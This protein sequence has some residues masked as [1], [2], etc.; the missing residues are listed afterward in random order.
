MGS[1][2]VASDGS[3]ILFSDQET[4][5]GVIDG[6]SLKLLGR[7]KQKDVY[8]QNGAARYDVRDLLAVSPDGKT[9]AW[10]GIESTADVFL[11]ELRTQTVRRRLPGDSYPVKRLAYSPDGSKLLSA[12]PDGSA[13]V[14]DLFDRHSLK[15][16][17]APGG[18]AV[19]AWWESLASDEAAPA[20]IAMRAMAARPVEALKLL[21]A[22]LPGP[23]VEPAVIDALI[24]R[25]G[26]RDFA[27]REAATKE[28]LLIGA[29]EPKLAAAAEKSES[30]EVRERAELVL[31]RLRR[32]G[33]LQAERAVEV[34]EWI[35]T[36][37][38][39]KFLEELASGAPDPRIK[40]DA[41]NA[42]AR[43]KAAAR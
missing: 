29:A 1:I 35:G 21:R 11:I 3:R 27:T 42:V 39:R 18:K 36:S 15:P 8:F 43:R 2:A 6:P 9:V 23:V 40:K 32:T 38:T 5:V 37:E 24:V 14:W 16:T 17:D 26:D 25:L 41:S 33:G 12:G 31:K 19:A 34:L 22:T 4:G 30:A 13:L 20:G 28:L 10:S 7:A